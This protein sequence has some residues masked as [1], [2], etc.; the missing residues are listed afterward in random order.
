M[1]PRGSKLSFLE[2]KAPKSA[3]AVIKV[4]EILAEEVLDVEP[5]LPLPKGKAK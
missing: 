4:E 1:H 3:K 5:E 2:G